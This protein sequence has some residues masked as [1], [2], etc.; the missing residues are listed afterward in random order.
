MEMKWTKQQQ[1]AISSEG[2]VIV[3]AGAG[4]GKT[5]VLVE[6]IMRLVK[7]NDIDRMLIVTFTNA[8]AAGMREDITDA[9]IAA[10][11]NSA[12]EEA[13]NY[14]RQLLL[15]PGAKICTIHSFCSALIR[16]NFEK[17]GLGTDFTLCEAGQQQIM[18][19][20]CMNSFFES[21]YENED[22]EFMLFAEAF[23]TSKNDT[24]L[25]E[26]V[27]RVYNFSR[28]LPYPDKWF[29]EILD[30]YGCKNFK[31]QSEMVRDAKNRIMLAADVYLTSAAALLKNNA[32]LS[33][34]C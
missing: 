30:V 28:A 3:S 15:L 10:A 18:F 11:E 34:R 9:L 1:E 6:R 17:L 8:A 24:A 25:F 13:E 23:C 7:T 5:T 20:E 33:G 2:A 29:D 12:P 22:A 32:A 26:I 21:C 31:W 4:S 27:K 19:D 14:R 16:D